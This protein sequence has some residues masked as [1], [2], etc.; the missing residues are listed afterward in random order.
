[1]KRRVG[2]LGGT[3]NP[4]HNGHIELGL[5]IKEAYKLNKIKYIL[6]AN[7]PHKEN[8]LIVDMNIRWNMLEKALKYIPYL[9]PCDIEIKRKSLSYTIDTVSSMKEK[10]PE[11]EFFFIMGSDG[12]LHI[13]TWKDYIKL[14]RTVSFIVLLREERHR[15]K[16]IMILKEI[17][18]KYTKGDLKENDAQ[19]NFNR[20]FFYS[21]KSDTLKNSSTTVRERIREGLSIDGLVNPA[22]A[23]IIKG[24]NLYG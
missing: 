4:V 5:K 20:V 9:E 7:P 10:Y 6:S 13:K 22:V 8:D 12:F 1:M 14:L 24:N 15:N 16:I 19:K 3:F 17:G 23:E 2:L 18:I 11:D 21:Y